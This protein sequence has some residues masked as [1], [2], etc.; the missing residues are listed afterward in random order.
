MNDKAS[1]WIDANEKIVLLLERVAYT[2]LAPCLPMNFWYMFVYVRV[3]V[4]TTYFGATSHPCAYPLPFNQST[5]CAWLCIA[6]SRGALWP[7]LQILSEVA[8]TPLNSSRSNSTI[9]L[10]RCFFQNWPV[11][12]SLII[13]SLAHG[14]GLL[15]LCFVHALLNE[16]HGRQ[17]LRLTMPPHTSQYWRYVWPSMLSWRLESS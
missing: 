10:C 12:L 7:T 2:C 17:T 16:E 6:T 13:S 3:G 14:Q 8:D 15:Y 4:V 5:A 1:W 9:C 11:R